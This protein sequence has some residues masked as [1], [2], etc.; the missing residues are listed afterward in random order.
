VARTD[1]LHTDRPAKAKNVYSRHR[2]TF[3]RQTGEAEDEKEEDDDDED[4]DCELSA[5]D[6]A[7]GAGPS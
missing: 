4:L 1:W 6:D 5:A 2:L 3:L 7:A